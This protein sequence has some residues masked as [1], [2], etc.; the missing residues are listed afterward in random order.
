MSKQ[1]N[2]A[3]EDQWLDAVEAASNLTRSQYLIWLGQKLAPAS[4]LYNMIFETRLEGPLD[5][6][7]FAS[8][9]DIVV[10]NNEALR[11]I[12]EERGG[13]PRW[14]CPPQASTSLVRIAFDHEHDP[15][16][17]YEAW[18]AADKTKPFDL[19]RGLTRSI[20]I[21]LGPEEHVWFLNQHHL[22]TDAWSCTLIRRRLAGAYARLTGAATGAGE[23][24]GTP[25]DYEAC[26]EE[27]RAWRG[28]EQAAELRAYWSER[29]QATLPR[30]AFFGHTA[31]GRDNATRRLQQRLSPR[32]VAA[33]TE[34]AGQPPFRG[35]TPAQSLANLLYT[36][37]FA[38]LA[39]ATGESRLV[40]GM[41]VHN[42]ASRRQRSTVGLFMEIFPVEVTV[43]M[44]ARLSDLGG[45]VAAAMLET[46]ARARAG[47]SDSAMQRSFE[48]VINF[49]PM[50]MPG[51]PGLEH[52]TRWVHA[53]A[54]D[55]GHRLRL[56]VH[57]LDGTGGL[58]L[59]FEFARQLFPPALRSLAVEQFNAIV[60]A[61]L[62]MSDVPL[63]ALSLPAGE[64]PLARTVAPPA[65]PRA[66]TA[67]PEATEDSGADGQA[68]GESAP[69]EGPVETRLAALWRELLAIEDPGR[70]DSFFDLGG[71]SL[72][73]V[74]LIAEIEEAFGIDFPLERLFDAPTIAGLASRIEADLLREIEALSDDEAAALLRKLG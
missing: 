31:H 61:L 34:A 22:V 41:P 17:A 30:L 62:A 26:R 49:L 32:R 46:L 19:A 59:E 14:V 15:A 18:L 60:E 45:R 71:A 72:T 63:S 70:H 6:D 55:V 48:V 3:G 50:T 37:M 68:G 25:G 29:T 10:A 11:A 33:V 43:D 53:D 67:A 24:T 57:D 51:F 36:A 1:Q 5:A 13:V 12:I 35:I 52:S 2:T 20:L 44:D 74:Q 73:A 38:W 69:P 54:G 58:T 47:I 9:W 56:P 4:P 27:E 23:D 40:I 66:G 42:R 39:R 21:R 65:R 16:A 7:A 64:Q 28:S 8:A